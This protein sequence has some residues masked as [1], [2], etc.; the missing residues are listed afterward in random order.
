VR[1]SWASA[2]A[3]FD[4]RARLAVRA[5]I[6]CQPL[7]P[8]SIAHA[9]FG[10]MLRLGDLIEAGAMLRGIKQRAKALTV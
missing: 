8:A 5:R 10:V 6:A 3:D 2:L 9:V 7:V 4:V 1:L